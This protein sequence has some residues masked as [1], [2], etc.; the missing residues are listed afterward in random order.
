[1]SAFDSAMLMI[2]DMSKQIVALEQQN[3]DL[4]LALWHINAFVN[5][6]NYCEIPYCAFCTTN[7][8]V[9]MEINKEFKN[10]A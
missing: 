6:R 9:S 1:M 5:I 10:E 4:K 3:W 7:L 2:E 8:D